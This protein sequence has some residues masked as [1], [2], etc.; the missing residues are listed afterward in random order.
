MKKATQDLKDYAVH[1]TADVE[2]KRRYLDPIIYKILQEY[3]DK[4]NILFDLGAG[5]G[6]YMGMI[7]G[8]GFTYFGFDLN[9]FYKKQKRRVIANSLHLPVASRSCDLVLANMLINS[10]N[11]IEFINL[12]FEA[13]R[14]MKLDSIIVISWLKVRY[15][16]RDK[17]FLRFD[18][19]P[20][21][22][23]TRSPRELRKFEM[24]VY[25]QTKLRVEE[26]LRRFG[27]QVIKVGS[28][29]SSPF[30]IL[31]GRLKDP[32]KDPRIP[33]FHV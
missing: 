26:T 19:N 20:A 17:R 4:G 9:P 8:V 14:V 6:Q 16:T 31:V 33:I 12:F 30:N 1:Y 2:S 10:L 32:E 13:R 28:N 23:L 29:R 27:F 7:R 3:F 15:R 21:N 24:E 22:K 25:Q 11:N 5:K 18:G